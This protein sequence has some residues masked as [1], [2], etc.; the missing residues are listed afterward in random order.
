MCNLQ[1]VMKEI[2]I[3]TGVITIA[4]ILE[5][6]GLYFIRLGGTMNVSIASIMYGLGIV[7]LLG[8]ATKYEGIG[9][10]NFIW[11][12]LST[13]FGFSIGIFVFKEKIRNMQLMGIGVSLLGLWM[14]L[15]DP[16]VK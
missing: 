13:I 6:L 3:A 7:P 14:I 5:A 2:Y 8:I 1:S 10:S 4:S 9:L 11:N 15:S 12:M 16:D